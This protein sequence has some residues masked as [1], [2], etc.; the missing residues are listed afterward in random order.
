[1]CRHGA[2][3]SDKNGGTA[4][5]LIG[6]TSVSLDALL[7][8]EPCGRHWLG[9]AYHSARQK[10][11]SGQYRWLWHRVVHAGPNVLLLLEIDVTSKPSLLHPSPLEYQ[12]H[13]TSGAS[14][15]E[16]MKAGNEDGDE[17]A[18]SNLSRRNGNISAVSVLPARVAPMARRGVVLIKPLKMRLAV[19]IAELVKNAAVATRGKIVKKQPPRLWLAARVDGGGLARLPPPPSS[20]LPP[21]PP[22]PLPLPPHFP[23]PRHR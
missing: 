22:P 10:R 18:L 14:S 20:L 4:R 23:P 8:P 2:G 15:V 1:M 21:P 7:N 16:G 12:M 9:T 13:G 5:R 19:P 11:L 6:A 3:R 17:Q